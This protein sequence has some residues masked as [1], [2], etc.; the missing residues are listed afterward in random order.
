NFYNNEQTGLRVSVYPQFEIAASRSVE[1]G[2]ADPGQ[3]LIIPLLVSKEFRYMTM[4]ANGG[5]EKPLHDQNRELTEIFG[6]GF[7]R[8][9]WRKVALMGDVRGESTFD[10]ERDRVVA[11]DAGIMYGVRS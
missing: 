11:A 5:I 9:M 2:L 1:N 8:A 3:T 7:G 4:V 10:F 6:L